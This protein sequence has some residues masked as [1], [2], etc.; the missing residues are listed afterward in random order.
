MFNRR[1]TKEGQ[2]VAEVI[3]AQREA[4]RVTLLETVDWFLPKL[5]EMFDMAETENPKAK[6]ITVFVKQY[7][8]GK[9]QFTTSPMTERRIIKN[10]CKS[11]CRDILNQMAVIANDHNIISEPF[12][13]QWDGCVYS[14]T[15]KYP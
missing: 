3:S 1:K 5:L 10:P 11:T 6:E 8:D 12:D 13:S 14:F 7:H 9:F 15:R 2:H 4:K